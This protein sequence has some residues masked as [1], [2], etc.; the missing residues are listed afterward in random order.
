MIDIEIQISISERSSGWAINWVRLC[1]VT[2]CQCNMHVLQTVHNVTCLCFHYLICQG[3]G[4]EKIWQINR[5]CLKVVRVRSGILAIAVEMNATVSQ[6][7]TMQNSK[8]LQRN[9][10]HHNFHVNQ[11]SCND[12]VW[13]ASRYSCHRLAGRLRT[14]GGIFF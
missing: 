10:F 13:L 1:I 6:W 14:G 12:Q 11:H 9:H 5:C 2:H 8:S 4:I 7:E 3:D